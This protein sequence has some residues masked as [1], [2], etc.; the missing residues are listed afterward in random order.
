MGKFWLIAAACL[1]VVGLIVLAGSM[2]FLN[3]NF[4]ALSTENFQTNTH[5]V[6]QDFTGITIDADT[7][8]ILFA[9]STDGGCQVICK[10]QKNITHTVIVR[11]D[12]LEIRVNDTR[13]WYE[14]IGIQLGTPQ[15]TV[16]L[17]KSAYRFLTVHCSTGDVALPRD[18]SFDSVEITTSTGDINAENITTGQLALSVSTGRIAASDL[19]CTG[20]ITLNVSTGKTKLTGVRCTNFS[21]RGRTGDLSVR[22]LI[23]EETISIVRSTGDVRLDNCDG[24]QIT[25]STDTGDV[26][27]TLLSEKVF[28]VTTD[29][30]RIQVPE[31]TAGGQC[32]ITTDTG[33]IQMR[34]VP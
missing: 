6:S 14:Y 8:D 18:F 20:N 17:P 4:S 21:S 34:L 33:N 10:E 11:D 28:L 9:P 3:W 24:A 7:A 30:G 15:I 25:V 27:G 31:T 16:C 32:R 2:S 1:V 23:A 22:D 5:S 13:K 26:S 12:T 29:T 19:T